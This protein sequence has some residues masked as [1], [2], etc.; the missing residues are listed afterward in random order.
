[1]IWLI[2][3]LPTALFFVFMPVL[4]TVIAQKDRYRTQSVY[5]FRSTRAVKNP[6][7]W[8]KAQ[9]AVRNSSFVFGGVQLVFTLLI[10]SWSEDL[11]L[12]ANAVFLGV[13]LGIQF[14]YV[15]SKLD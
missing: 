7:N 12:I 6:E 9:L 11:F 13:L 2:G 4:E 5:G 14:L 10:C 8:R 1:M 15:N 3:L